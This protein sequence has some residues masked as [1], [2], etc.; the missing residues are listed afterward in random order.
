VFPDETTITVFAI[1]LYDPDDIWDVKHL[2]THLDGY[3]HEYS[4][5]HELD[6]SGHPGANGGSMVG[7]GTELVVDSVGQLLSESYPT[8]AETWRSH[9]EAH[10]WW[11]NAPPRVETYV[12]VLKS[13]V[14]KIEVTASIT[15]KLSSPAKRPKTDCKVALG[16]VMTGGGARI[17]FGP[18]PSKYNF[19]MDDKKVLLTASFPSDIDTWEGRAKDHGVA[20]T[21]GRI[22]VYCVGVKVTES[23]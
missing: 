17:D 9:A 15:S 18:R 16:C 21:K 12:T 19:R 3:E 1:A 20:Y 13:K 7:G 5:A 6:I 4:W 23:A 11:Y 10:L 8:N 22:E 2:Y 14:E